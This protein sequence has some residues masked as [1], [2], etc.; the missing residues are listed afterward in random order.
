MNLMTAPGR[1]TIARLNRKEE[2]YRLT[3]IPAEF[4]T[5]PVEKMKETTEEWP[6]VYARL[7]FDHQIFLDEF[8]A[9]H[10][11]AVYGDKTEDLKMVCRMLDIE[12][13]VLGE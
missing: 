6:H 7:P 12:V 4:V 2:K 13:E 8:D 11:H 3:V 5:L 10:C 9:N 1:A